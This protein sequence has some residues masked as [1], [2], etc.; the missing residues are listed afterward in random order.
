MFWTAAIVLPLLPTIIVSPLFWIID[1]D[2]LVTDA[3]RSLKVIGRTTL[4]GRVHGIESLDNPFHRL[5]RGVMDDYGECTGLVC[6]RLS[7]VAV[8]A[9]AMA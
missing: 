5:S 4:V 7:V 3:V 8:H 6:S 9:C 2:T 1:P